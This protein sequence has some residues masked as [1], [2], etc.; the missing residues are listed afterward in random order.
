MLPYAGWDTKSEK[1]CVEMRRCHCKAGSR[2]IGQLEPYDA[3]KYSHPADDHELCHFRANEVTT[4]VDRFTQHDKGLR[5][6]KI[7]KGSVKEPLRDPRGD[8]WFKGPP[9]PEWVNPRFRSSG[10]DPEEEKPF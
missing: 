8:D 9:K 5:F 7:K 4:G 3:G 6:L 1:W 2:Y 10:P